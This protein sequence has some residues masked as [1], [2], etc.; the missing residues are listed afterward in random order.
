MP[1]AIESDVVPRLLSDVPAQPT[2]AELKADR[3][4]C[5]FLMIF[6]REGYS[7]AFFRRMWQLH[8][9]ACI[10]YHKFPKD[11]W[12][13]AEFSEVT[14]TMPR[15]ETVKMKLAERG[16]YVGSRGDGL[17]VREIRKLTS[18][19]QRRSGTDHRTHGRI[20]RYRI[21]SSPPRSGEL[22]LW[23]SLTRFDWSLP[24]RITPICRF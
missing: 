19:G 5:R 12:P 20:G 17:W 22:L 6:D 4:R 18:S 7:P 9:V 11:D 14:A 15:G 10:T 21:A 23:W 3:Y 13:T 24:G 16:S 1:E 2:D 8:R